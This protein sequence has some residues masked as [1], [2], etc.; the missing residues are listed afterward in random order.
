[1]KK[2]T[3][4]FAL[5]A[6]LSLAGCGKSPKKDD[7]CKT[8]TGDFE[9]PTINVDELKITLPTMPIPDTT[10]A[11]KN[12]G[13]YDY[14]D[15]YELS[16]LHGAIDY[17]KDDEDTQFGLPRLASFM[18]AKR[19]ENKGTILISGGDMWQGSCESNLTRGK[20]MTESMRYLGFDCMT[21]GNHEFDW[22]SSI[23]EKNKSY[24]GDE[25]PYLCGNLIDTQ[26]G[27][28][29]S[30]VKG[31]IVV[32]RGGYKVGIVGTMGAIQKSIA[33]KAFANYSLTP[34][35]DYIESEALRLRNEEHCDFVVWSSHEDCETMYISNP[36]NIDAAFGGHEHKV[37]NKKNGSVPYI[38]TDKYGRN[39]AHVSLKIDPA[40]KQLV[41]ATGEVIDGAAVDNSAEDSNLVNLIN[42]YRVETDKV[43][44][45]EISK[46]SGEFKQTNELANVCVKAMYEIAK[47]SEHPENNPIVALTNGDGGVRAPLNS[48]VITYGDVY[49]AFPFDNELV[50]YAVKGNQVEDLLTS[51]LKSLNIYHENIKYSQ[52]DG[53]K[54]YYFVMTDFIATNY[55]KL[56]ES[57]YTQ[58][59]LVCRD[60]VA[61]YIAKNCG[62]KAS[63]YDTYSVSNFA[64]PTRN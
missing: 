54:T 40:T 3:S 19:N 20:L 39:L 5:I 58:L 37:V 25:L 34:S 62:M 9:I 22:T 6:V 32:E 29:P 43:K 50:T 11:V 33:K 52:L 46:V 41:E 48:G 18:Q 17:L 21:L 26:T 45:V 42:Q 1:M 35:K 56:N 55:L 38:E 61:K 53:S 23:I 28:R 31:S 14:I 16:D 27:S 36:S 4:L 12:D 63:S 30:F 59:D 44:K 15:L 64:L 13:T 49:Q 47:D 51:K 10:S 57:K 60:V 8:H 7:F 2:F 24:F